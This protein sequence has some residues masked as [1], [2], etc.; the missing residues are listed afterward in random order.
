MKLGASHCLK[1][2]EKQHS[3]VLKGRLEHCL[4]GIL[5]N[6]MHVHYIGII[7]RSKSSIFHALNTP[8]KDF[9]FYIFL[10]LHKINEK[11]K[12]LTLISTSGNNPLFKSE[13]LKSYVIICFILK[14][15]RIRKQVS[16][17]DTSYG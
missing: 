5:H 6:N 2:K 14:A 9:N 8:G 3:E 11:S 7:K 12:M 10:H 1:V 16:F 15:E 4:K 13:D 17:T